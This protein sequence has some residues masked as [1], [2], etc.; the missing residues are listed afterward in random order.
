[1]S[2]PIFI[3]PEEQAAYAEYAEYMTD[4]GLEAI[5][6]ERWIGKFGT[7]DQDPEDMSGMETDW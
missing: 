4:L 3:L 1:M 5:P 6:I 7:G 2:R